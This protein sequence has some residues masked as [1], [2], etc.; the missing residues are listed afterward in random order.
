MRYPPA[1]VNNRRNARSR[2]VCP[3]QVPCSMR[4]KRSW[5]ALSNASAIAEQVVTLVKYS[6]AMRYIQSGSGIESYLPKEILCLFLC[7]VPPLRI[8][9]CQQEVLITGLPRFDLVAGQPLWHG[10]M[11]WQG[12]SL[13]P[14]VHC[15]EVCILAL[16]HLRQRRRDGAFTVG[17]DGGDELGDHPGG[18][19]LPVRLC[20]HIPQGLVGLSEFG[21]ESGGS[22]AQGLWSPGQF[23]EIMPIREDFGP[24]RL[25]RIHV[26]LPLPG[27][28][29]L[30]HPNRGCDGPPGPRRRDRV[31]G[32][33][34]LDHSA[35]IDQETLRSPGVEGNG[36][37]SPQARTLL[38]QQ[39]PH[40]LSW[41]VH[42]GPAGGSHIGAYRICDGLEG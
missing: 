17:Y 20:Q 8:S 22:L 3:D 6:N 39:L 9:C 36:R 5:E 1:T 24:A 35:V 4:V 30:L 40:G 21:Q 41:G 13:Q 28:A 27:Q 31:F 25:F 10:D 11:C 14:C 32:T 29:N 37:K 7:R 34:N 18:F 12:H 2:S 23:R 16:H 38:L 19:T 15:V 33:F 42:L 26:G